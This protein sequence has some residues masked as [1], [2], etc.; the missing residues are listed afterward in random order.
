MGRRVMEAICFIGLIICAVVI[1]CCTDT[2]ER[3]LNKLDVREDKDFVTL[4]Q[5]YKG[6]YNDQKDLE[7]RILNLEKRINKLKNKNDD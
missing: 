5:R 6:I 4:F 3:R 7:C 2:L 1:I